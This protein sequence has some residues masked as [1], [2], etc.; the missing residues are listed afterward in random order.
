MT[1]YQRSSEFKRKREREREKKERVL[2]SIEMIYN[3]EI[4]R[5]H[6]RTQIIKIRNGKVRQRPRVSKDICAKVW[7]KS[8]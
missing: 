1:F 8:G 4:T 2:L 6:D 5:Q 7:L 3:S